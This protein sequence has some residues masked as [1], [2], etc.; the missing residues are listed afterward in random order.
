[1]RPNFTIKCHLMI[2]T[3]SPHPRG[4]SELK[5][6]GQVNYK[7]YNRAR[8]AAS[9]HRPQVECEFQTKIERIKGGRADASPGDVKP[10]QGRRSQEPE[11]EAIEGGA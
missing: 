6:R 9:R 8:C 2:D 10:R 5:Y 3:G 4:G 11:E 1:M 7:L